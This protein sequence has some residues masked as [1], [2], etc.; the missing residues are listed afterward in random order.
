MALT[1]RRKLSSWKP[2]QLNQEHPVDVVSTFLEPMR[3]PNEYKGRESEF[4]DFLID[5][6]FA[7][8]IRPKT[9]RVL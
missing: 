1:V 6:V 5:K 9:G 3:V 2:Q 8:G 4:I 7:G